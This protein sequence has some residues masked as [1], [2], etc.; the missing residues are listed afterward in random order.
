MPATKKN[1]EHNRVGIVFNKLMKQIESPVDFELPDWFNKWKPTPY[2]FIK[3]NIYLT[4]RIKRRLEDDGIFCSCC[5]SPGSS[6]VCDRDCHCGMLLSSCS[7]GC[8]C[9]SSCLNKPFQSRPVKKMKLVKTE[10]CG[11]GIVAD[12][13]IK[14]G[15]FVI[16]YVGEVI[17]DKTCEERL[18]NMKH[19]G[20]TN[21]YLCEINR[22]MVIDATYKG[23]KSRY[24]NHSCC[25]NT[26]MQKWIIDGETRIGIFATRCIKK[27]EHLTYD[28]QF[29]QFGADQDCHCGATDCRRKLG[30]RPAKPKMS[31][32]A[33]LKLVAYQVAVSSPKLKAILS[34]KDNGGLHVGSSHVRNEPKA[35]SRNCIGEVIRITRPM[36]ERSFGIIK[37]FDKF[38]KKHSIM[39]EDGAVEFLDMT[40]E[41]WELA[42]L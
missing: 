38:S 39:F 11:S 32:D 27:G 15:E 22:D 28:Y 16:E 42:M 35:F 4:K 19:R 7:S 41:D 37:R 34:G 10:K 23:N 8:K 6:G 21:F 12:E 18:W 33:A 29:V 9:G 31:S 26:E 5:L 1:P 25:P 24:I 2:T 40:K 30:V 17:D 3:R 13:D 14:Q 20:E 36:N